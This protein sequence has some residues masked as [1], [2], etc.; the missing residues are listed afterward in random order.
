I[1]SGLAL[2]L[3][4]V[5]SRSQA[6]IVSEILFTATS[7]VAIVIVAGERPRRPYATTLSRSLLLLMGGA[8]G[9]FGILGVVPLTGLRTEYRDE[10]DNLLLYGPPFTLF[11]IGLAALL[12]TLCRRATLGRALTIAVTLAIAIVPVIASVFLRVAG[13]STVYLQA[14]S[15]LG[16]FS[17]SA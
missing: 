10:V 7:F 15:P 6:V 16:V 4:L 17:G 11:V 13:V 5:P 1:I 2:L 9:I 12:R 8:G 3:G 14:A